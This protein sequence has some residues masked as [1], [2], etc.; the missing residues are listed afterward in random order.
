MT[1]RINTAV[2]GLARRNQ[3][4]SEVAAKKLGVRISSLIHSPRMSVGSHGFSYAVYDLIDDDRLMVEAFVNSDSRH[5]RRYAAILVNE[6]EPSIEETAYCD[7][8]EIYRVTDEL[9]IGFDDLARAE[10]A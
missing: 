7:A 2:F 8:D 4:N 3:D 1:N 5:A 6:F 9:G 10:S